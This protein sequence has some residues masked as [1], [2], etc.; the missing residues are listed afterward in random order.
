MNEP[1]ES[2]PMSLDK[3]AEAAL[4]RAQLSRAKS[5]RES[6]NQD[7]ATAQE[8]MHLREWQSRR[9]A[10]THRD[11]LDS[12]R[13]GTPATF[14]LSDLYGPKDFSARDE[15]L[16]R[17]L[18]MVVSMLPAAGVHTVG[19]A[20]EVDALS[21]E[22]D[23]AMVRALRR[24]GDVERIDDRCYGEAYRACDSRDARE[25]QIVLIG[26]TG[27][28]LARLT[29]MPLVALALSLMRGPA[30]LAGLGELHDFLQHG[31]NAF[32]HMG[33]PTEF[34]DLIRQRETAVME[35]LFA[36]HPEPFDIELP[37]PA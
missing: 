16:E 1:S 7:P 18:P 32:R 24:T 23:A 9:L 12:P 33:D 22:L 34:L 19:L 5:L 25:R 26:D 37:S 15:E 13:Y 31:F 17:I 35:R 4:L 29:R 10:R 30:H 2:T 27:R 3:D 36:A 6:A 28:A 20:V 8:R 11:L 14:F 21:E